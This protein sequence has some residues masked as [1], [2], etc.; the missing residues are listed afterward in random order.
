MENLSHHDG[1]TSKELAKKGY[2]IRRE[3]NDRLIDD[4]V[5][6]SQEE[7][8]K[9]YTPDD[10]AVRFKDKEPADEWYAKRKRLVYA[11][12]KGDDL[13]GVIWY[14]ENPQEGLGARYT[15]AIRLYESASG[16]GLSHQFMQDAQRDFT[17]ETG[18][19]DVW[20]KVD[21]SNERAI[22]LYIKFGYEIA[23]EQGDSWLMEY[24]GQKVQ[25]DG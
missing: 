3:W 11:M 24:A 10:A 7:A 1:I 22:H 9:T 18:E 8:I 12:Y 23:N 2:E 17:A 13:A 6:K 4:L 25:Q 20:L 16:Q 14:G 5:E 15:F 19:T 21:K